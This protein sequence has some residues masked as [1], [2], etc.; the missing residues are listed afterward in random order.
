MVGKNVTAQDLTIKLLVGL[1]PLDR[2]NVYRRARNQLAEQTETIE[3]LDL[4]VMMAGELAQN[5]MK[6]QNGFLALAKSILARQKN[7]SEKEITKKEIWGKMQ[8][9]GKEGKNLAAGSGNNTLDRIQDHV[10]ELRPDEIRC[11]CAG[12]ERKSNRLFW[13]NQVYLIFPNLRTQ[14]AAGGPVLD[15]LQAVWNSLPQEDRETAPF[16]FLSYADWFRQLEQPQENKTCRMSDELGL[17]DLLE[18]ARQRA[19]LFKTEL[20]NILEIDPDTYAS[21]K[22]AWLLFEKNGCNGGFPRNRLSRERLLCLAIHLK[23]DFYTAVALLGMAGY[24]FPIAASD[25][26]VAG[27]LWDH[28]Y[29]RKEALDQLHL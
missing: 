28:R 22:R 12:F 19:N 9:T 16:V 7:C 21:Y 17:Y 18:Q 10:R 3:Q 26:V 1:D 11:L 25:S 14:D 29:S 24:S 20:Y 27:Y 15:C 2:A 6:Y 4:C 13:E 5:P 23:M 8:E